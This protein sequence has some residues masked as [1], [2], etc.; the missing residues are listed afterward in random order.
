[1]NGTYAIETEK[2]SS[3]TTRLVKKRIRI[4]HIGYIAVGIIFIFTAIVAK[5]L[6]FFIIGTILLGG[7]YLFIRISF[8]YEQQKISK[9]LRIKVTDETIEKLFDISEL[10]ENKKT[11]A[12]SE[13]SLT[14]THKSISLVTI[15]KHEIVIQAVSTKGK[16]TKFIIP[17]EIQEFQKFREFTSELS[18]KS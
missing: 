10:P 13:I 3:Y 16:K 14:I 15:N 5:S 12:L 9:S 11:K 7:I 18:Y 17:N 2:Q 6:H 8:T 1:M 4:V